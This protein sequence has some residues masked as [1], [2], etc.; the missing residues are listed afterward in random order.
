MQ[1]VS[2]KHEIIFYN[3]IYYAIGIAGQNLSLEF[4][5]ALLCGLLRNIQYQI[6]NLIEAIHDVYTG[7]APLS[8]SVAKKMLGFFAHQN[9]IL[10]SPGTN[11]Y[12]LSDRE[13][14][15]LQM[16]VKGDNYKTIAEKAFISYETVR[17]HVK[18]IYKKLHVTSRNEAMM[19]AIQ[20]GLT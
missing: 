10:V 3:K 11:D 19:K 7:G 2:V 1:W 17:T 5:M 20:H 6:W 9:V 16:I 4:K 15:L 12:Q 13:R 14:E 18:H 8:S